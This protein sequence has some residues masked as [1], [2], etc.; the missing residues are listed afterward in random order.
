MNLI[1]FL[2]R[3]FAYNEW[4]NRE[5][6]NSLR[7]AADARSLELMAH[8]LGAEILWMD[9][10]Q[11]RPQ[12]VPVWPGLDLTTCELKA[13]EVAT[14]WNEYLKA[15]T[16]ADLSGD[17]RYTNSKGEPWTSTVLDVLDHVILH[18]AY[19]RGQIASHMRSLGQT[20][21]YSDFIHATRQGLVK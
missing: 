12:S 1:D 16:D 7:R 3:Q 13:R 5:V 4:A 2:R 21:A 15:L 11:Q 8:I 17:A 20:P 9:R 6:L 10:L 14:S 19:H 18:S